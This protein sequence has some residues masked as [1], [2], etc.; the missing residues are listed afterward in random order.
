M[1]TAFPIATYPLSADT[2]LEDEHTV[3]VDIFDDGEMQSR[4][5]GGSTFRVINCVFQPM[6]LDT[7]MTFEQYLRTNRGIEWDLPI[8]YGSPQTTYRGYII[9]AV[10]PNPSEGILITFGFRFRGK[11]V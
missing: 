2:R 5:L 7:A 11:V 3:E 8:P 4:T 6:S 10:E 9:S 1:A